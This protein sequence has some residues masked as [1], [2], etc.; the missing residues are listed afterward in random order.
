MNLKENAGS[1]IQLITT[2]PLTKVTDVHLCEFLK[3]ETTIIRHEQLS[4]SWML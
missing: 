3:L 2:T 4:S 1:Y